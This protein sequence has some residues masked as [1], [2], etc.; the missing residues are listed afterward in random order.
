MAKKNDQIPEELTIEKLRT[1]KGCEHFTDEEAQ[2]ILDTF[3]GLAQVA[4]EFAME[5]ELKRRKEG[6]SS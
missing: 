6:E 3:D 5:Q 2:Q 4:F 1:Y